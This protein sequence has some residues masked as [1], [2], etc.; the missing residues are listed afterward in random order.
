MEREEN[1][2]L[3]HFGRKNCFEVPEGYFDT[4]TENIMSKLPEQAEESRQSATTKR[5]M[6]WHVRW[7]RVAAFIGILTVSSWMALYYFN[8]SENNRT[9]T[10]EI[11]NAA[12]STIDEMVDYTMM[13]NEDIYASLI[14]NN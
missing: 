12:Y 4:L 11:G 14:E 7:A 6:R 3:K 5:S 8:T 13:D 9:A 2:I 10:S 1:Q